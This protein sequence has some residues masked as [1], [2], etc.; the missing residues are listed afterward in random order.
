MKDRHSATFLTS[1]ESTAEEE[2]CFLSPGIEGG[3]VP[4]SKKDEVIIP[5]WY[6]AEGATICPNP[7]FD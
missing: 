6:R 2:L 1:A 3:R 5:K 7:D 4:G